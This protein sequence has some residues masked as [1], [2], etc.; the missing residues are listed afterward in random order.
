L[1]EIKAYVKHYHLIPITWERESSK[2]VYNVRKLEKLNGKWVQNTRLF[3]E[4]I[5]KK[6]LIYI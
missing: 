3:D 5:P 1:I 2:Y 4:K 6:E